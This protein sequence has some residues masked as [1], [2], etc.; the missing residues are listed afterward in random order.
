MGELR[1]QMFTVIQAPRTLYC[2]RPCFSAFM[3]TQEQILC[4]VFWSLQVEKPQG[5]ITSYHPISSM[6]PMTARWFPQTLFP[7][8]PAESP[9]YPKTHLEPLA[10]TQVSEQPFGKAESSMC[11]QQEN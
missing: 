10:L 1:I 9:L 7:R 2:V 3:V 11:H 6:L 5:P 4:T 8:D